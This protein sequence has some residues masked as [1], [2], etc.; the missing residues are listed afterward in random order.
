M[1]SINKI[2]VGDTLWKRERQQ[3]GNTTV[4]RTILREFRVVELREQ[5]GRRT[6]AVLS[7]M[8]RHMNVSATRLKGYLV[9]KPEPKGTRFGLPTY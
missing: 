1:A 3:M 9:R 6:V 5:N 8:G 2:S 4:R 7:C